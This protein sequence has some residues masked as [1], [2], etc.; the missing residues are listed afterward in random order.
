MPFLR[1]L[2]IALLLG[3]CLSVSPSHAEPPSRDAVQQ[4]L[5]GLAQRKLA[6]ADQA[7]VQQAL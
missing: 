1:C 4:S 2:S 5:D 3:F 7:A 6:E